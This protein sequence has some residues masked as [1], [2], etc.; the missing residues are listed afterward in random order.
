MISNVFLNMS[1]AACIATGGGISRK[2]IDFVLFLIIA[3]E[4]NYCD[5]IHEQSSPH[6]QEI[7]LSYFSLHELTICLDI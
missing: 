5:I 3:Q 7:K 6:L 2:E 1:L 4:I